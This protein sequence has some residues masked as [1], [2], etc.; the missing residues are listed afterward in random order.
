MPFLGQPPGHALD[1]QRLRRCTGIVD[2]GRASEVN[3][4]IARLPHE[5]GAECVQTVLVGLLDPG[6]LSEKRTFLVPFQEDR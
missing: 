5:T 2:Y 6:T 4:R 1:L 3:V